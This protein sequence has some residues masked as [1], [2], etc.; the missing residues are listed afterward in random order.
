MKKFLNMD[1]MKIFD[2]LTEKSFCEDN[3]VIELFGLEYIDTISDPDE[4]GYNQDDED[5]E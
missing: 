4:D 2:I 5:D 1:L 3:G